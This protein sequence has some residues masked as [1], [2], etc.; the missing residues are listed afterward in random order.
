VKPLESQ[1]LYDWLLAAYQNTRRSARQFEPFIRKHGIDMSEFK[2]VAY[3]S[4]ANSS[5]GSSRMARGN[6]PPS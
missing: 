4:F 2:P 3:Q 6:F 5:T 1:P